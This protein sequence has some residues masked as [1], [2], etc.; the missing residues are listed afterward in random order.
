MNKLPWLINVP[1]SVTKKWD[2]L[3]FELGKIADDVWEKG[4]VQ[5]NFHSK[6]L[7]AIGKLQSFYLHVG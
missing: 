4:V 5:K 3:R 1:N 7:D 2:K 6:L